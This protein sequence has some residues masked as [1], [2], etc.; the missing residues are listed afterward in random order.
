MHSLDA[1]ALPN[2]Q[3]L[4]LKVRS[5]L[6]VIPLFA[7]EVIE[8]EAVDAFSGFRRRVEWFLNNRPNLTKN[9]A[10][11]KAKGTEGK[12]LLS[13]VN[14]EKLKKIL[15]KLLD[16]TEFLSAY[17]IRSVSK[18]HETHPYTFSA[19]GREFRL[20]YEPAESRS[21]LFGGNSNWRGPIWFP[22]NYLLVESL[23]KFH[24]YLSNDFRVE[25]PTGSGEWM[26]LAEVVTELSYRLTNI[27]L[28]NEAGSRPVYGGNSRFQTDH[29]G[30]DL[31]LFHEYFHG[32]NGAGLGAN[33]QTGWTGLAATLISTL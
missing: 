24:Q 19:D 15:L 4:H 1:F 6:G 5:M 31:L 18:F 16:E 33:H 28:R 25:C 17:G 22:V 32:D 7:T 20:Q 30:R 27:F 10:Y 2:R 21:S 26:T 8:L 3:S 11:L 14:L 9:I 13:L 23:Q 12:R 29:K